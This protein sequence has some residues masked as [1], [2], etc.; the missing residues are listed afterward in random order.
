MSGDAT[1]LPA[2][3]YDRGEFW[4]PVL[5]IREGE[6]LQAF[7]ARYARMERLAKDA[8]K[9]VDAKPEQDAG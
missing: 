5:K 1:P 2:L 4:R 9:P 3:D 6:A 8:C 7:I